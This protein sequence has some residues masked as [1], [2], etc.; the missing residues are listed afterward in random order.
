MKSILRTLVSCVVLGTCTLSLRAEEPTE[1]QT[2]VEAYVR[3]LNVKKENFEE[4]M[5]SQVSPRLDAI[6][7]T[8]RESLQEM[9][10]HLLAL[11][12]DPNDEARKEAYEQSLNKALTNSQQVLEEFSAIEP[13]A[14]KAFNQFSR[15][16][17]T[18]I[19]KAEA[20]LAK[21]NQDLREYAE[22]KVRLT[23][24]LEKLAA[25]HEQILTSASP[26]L[27]PDLALD[28]KLT[29]T[30]LDVAT[31]YEMLSKVDLDYSKTLLKELKQ[32]KSELSQIQQNLRVSVHK[33][34]G[35]QLILRK[36]SDIKAKGNS[37]RTLNLRLHA[38][39]KSMPDIGT[40]LKRMEGLFQTFVNHDPILHPSS[41]K[42][43]VARQVTAGNEIEILKRFLPQS[44]KELVHVKP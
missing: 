5:E 22:R 17:E 31:Q 1:T 13:Q 15:S 14:M 2:E 38:I 24:A 40:D 16:V 28:V 9:E 25:Q 12:R 20:G 39:A 30:D 8:F 23:A 29:A 10:S 43:I 35:M 27:D 36:I 11:R 37:V 26:R 33:A 42:N 21:S 34:D 4:A 6:R 18:A 19:G 41:R 3:E 32:Q 44:K 7:E